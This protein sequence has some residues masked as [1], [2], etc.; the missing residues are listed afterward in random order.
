MII[1][2]NNDNNNKTG[3]TTQM[4]GTI[5]CLQWPK[6]ELNKCLWFFF[7]PKKVLENFRKSKPRLHNM[8]DI[9][10]TLMKSGRL[11]E[12][13]TDELERVINVIVAKWESIDNRLN[14]SRDRWYME[15]ISLRIWYKWVVAVNITAFKKTLTSKIILWDIFKKLSERQN[16][17]F[18]LFI[19]FTR[20]STS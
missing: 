15:G 11:D 7:Y 2:G 8:N 5:N 9:A 16:L 1:N 13:D 12:E 14:A 20:R 17:S 3:F 6:P 10:A 18:L 19:G 4:L